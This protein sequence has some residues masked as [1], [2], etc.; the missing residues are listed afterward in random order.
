MT[1]MGVRPAKQGL[2]SSCSLQ[3]CCAFAL[4]WLPHPEC[5]ISEPNC[6][7]VPALGPREALWLGLANLRLQ[8]LP[9]TSK[10][11]ACGCHTPC[12]QPS[13]VAMRSLSVW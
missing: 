2:W 6:I 4:Q 12:S 7:A 8:R 13:V 9:C 5:S 1:R 3:N 11:S 10:D